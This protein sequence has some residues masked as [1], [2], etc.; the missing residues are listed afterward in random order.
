MRI[1]KNFTVRVELNGKKL[2]SC[3]FKI[4][5]AML[6]VRNCR[7]GCTLPFNGF[8]RLHLYIAATC[9][10]DFHMEDFALKILLH[11][12]SMSIPRPTSLIGVINNK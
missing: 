3:K 10:S 6:S 12:S 8:L 2:H 5:S 11:A 9:E 4:G 1:Q 7:S